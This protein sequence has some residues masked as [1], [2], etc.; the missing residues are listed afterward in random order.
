MEIKCIGTTVEY[1]TNIAVLG[2]AIRETKNTVL[3]NFTEI[4]IFEEPLQEYYNIFN[5]NL[6]GSLYI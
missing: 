5:L 6:M 3:E 2:T 4:D 1:Y